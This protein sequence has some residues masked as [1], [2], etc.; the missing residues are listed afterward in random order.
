MTPPPLPPDVR[1]RCDAIRREHGD[2]IRRFIQRRLRSDE[3]DDVEAEVW[4][5]VVA[6]VASGAEPDNPRAFALAIARRRV[7]DVWRRRPPGED[8]DVADLAENPALSA[9]TTPTGRIARR[10]AAAA[11]REAIA[12]LGPAER[13][14]LE[15]RFVDGLK[16]A[17]IAEILGDSPNT[18]SKRVGRAV[19]RLAEALRGHPALSGPR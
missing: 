7:V 2:A 14:V 10:E 17:E 6:A 8:R 18:V 4:S 3:V 15:L 9:V 16:P 19:E 13:E 12:S 5:G 1:A 11:L